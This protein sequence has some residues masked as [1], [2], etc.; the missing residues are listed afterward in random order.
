MLF[1][2]MWFGGTWVAQSVQDPT[3]AQVM[4]SWFMSLSPV[5]GSVLTARSLEA[6]SDSV[7]LPLSLPLPCSCSVSISLKNKQILKKFFKRY[8]LEVLGWLSR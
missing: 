8:G 2:T 1:K 6:A 7:C 4:I 3:L 5:S